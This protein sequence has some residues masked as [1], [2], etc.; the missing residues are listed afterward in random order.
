MKKHHKFLREDDNDKPVYRPNKEEYG[1]LLARKYYAK[2][3]KEYAIV[4]LQQYEQGRIGCRW[5]TEKEVI[6]SKG[7]RI[8]G[9]KK[10]SNSGRETYEFNFAY[11]EDG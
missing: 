7:E 2:L 10:C 6:V 4:D 8:C 3:Y 1:E 5:R 9:N 11:Q